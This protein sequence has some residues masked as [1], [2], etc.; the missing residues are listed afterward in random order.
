[1]R[2]SI[3][4]VVVLILLSGFVAYFGDLLGRKMGKK[5]L[6]L[7][8]MRPRYTAILFTVITGMVIAAIALGALV[9]ANKQFRKVLI[10]GD[11]ILSQ[12]SFLKKTNR[13][14]DN[15]N[16]ELT[17]KGK[18][19]AVEAA[20]KVKE[21][22]T[23]RKDAAKFLKA[24]NEAQLT[25]RKLEAD[26][27]IK[28]TELENLKKSSQV[29]KAQLKD[30]VAQLDQVNKALT[31]ARSKLQQFA[32]T[33]VDLRSGI[34]ILRQGDEITR[35]I[36]RTNQSSVAIRSDL[37]TLL[38][39]ASDRALKMGAAKGSNSRAVSVMF[40]RKINDSL[41]YL[42]RNE[43]LF[44]KQ[45]ADTI[46]KA[47][48]HDQVLVQVMCARNTL[49]NEQVPVELKLY[50]N[51]VIFRQNQK[52]ADGRI[53]G[54]QSEGRILMDLIA[55][56]QSAVGRAALQEG[57][58]PV[59][60]SPSRTGSEPNPLGQVEALMST[61]DKIKSI[62]TAVSITVYAGRDIRAEGPLNMDNMRVDVRKL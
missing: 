11:A 61:A 26:I 37:R 41:D 25:V 32:N 36:V 55:F 35:G 52:I 29:T 16:T 27:A 47:G 57:I 9:S 28:K 2:Y 14:L 12:N 31:A 45:A 3:L 53:D 44:I 46:L 13:E 1:M 33:S 22:D 10:E 60:G 58:I 40:R 51:D 42:E 24:R 17:D 38:Q 20:Q 18:A 56:L 30:L 4:F 5:R 6:T 54:R 62:N 50:P 19:L 49:R 21:A 7:F 15:Q 43:L 59:S 23:A 8:H 39:V 48:S 34:M